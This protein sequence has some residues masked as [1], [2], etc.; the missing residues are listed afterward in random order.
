M[1]WVLL[2]VVL[3]VGSVLLLVALAFGLWGKVKL[4]RR[5]ATELS[6]RVTGLSQEAGALSARLDPDQVLGRLADR[7]G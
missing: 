7:T 2:D 5:T 1:R 6:G 3:M 4:V